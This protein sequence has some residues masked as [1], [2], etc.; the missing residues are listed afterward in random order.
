MAPFRPV[1]LAELDA[2]LVAPPRD[3]TGDDGAAHVEARRPAA[4]LMPVM[5]TQAGLAMLLTQR[6][7]TMRDHAGQIA[8]PGG[9]VDPE[10]ATPLAAALR[11]TR[12]EVGIPP[13]RMRVLGRIET[14]RT[15]TGFLITPFVALV[16][17]DVAPVAEPGEVDDIFAPPLDFLMNPAHHQRRTGEWRGARRRYW[18]IPWEGRFIWGA[19]A[20]MLRRLAERIEAARTP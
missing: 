16:E 9:K 4:V 7:D 17:P 13:D 11:E 19:T 18:A 5:Q 6:P 8:F 1:A 10:D 14:Y 15:G 3:P 12:E 2:A 20:G